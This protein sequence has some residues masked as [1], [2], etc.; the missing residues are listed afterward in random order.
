MHACVSPVLA[1][2]VDEGASDCLAVGVRRKFGSI[3]WAL[4]VDSDSGR[5][6]WWWSV[7][8]A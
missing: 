5:W 6:W 2:L 8:R 7:E 1:V 4:F 3:E